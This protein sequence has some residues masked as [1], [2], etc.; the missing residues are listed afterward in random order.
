MEA[1]ELLVEIN[2][3]YDFVVSSITTYI[4]AEGGTVVRRQRTDRSSVKTKSRLVIE[5]ICETEDGYSFV[6]KPVWQSIDKLTRAK[7][8]SSW[9]HRQRA[10]HAPGLEKLEKQ[11]TTYDGTAKKSPDRLDALTTGVAGLAV[12]RRKAS[13]GGASPTNL[14]PPPPAGTPVHP[15]LTT[16]TVAAD[17]PYDTRI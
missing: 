7:A 10:S 6:L 11:Q 13:A 8:A 9:W 16:A 12:T 2:N 4:E 14:P 15:L 17:N 5:Y 3:G 1:D